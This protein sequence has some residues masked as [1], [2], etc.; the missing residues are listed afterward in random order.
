MGLV[1]PGGKT[2]QQERCS[3][4]ERLRLPGAI[5]LPSLRDFNNLQINGADSGHGAI[6]TPS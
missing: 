1:T 3:P 6:K 5:I 2:E 4:R